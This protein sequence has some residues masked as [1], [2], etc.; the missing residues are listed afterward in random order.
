MDFVTKT[1]TFTTATGDVIEAITYHKIRKDGTPYKKPFETIAYKIEGDKKERVKR[2]SRCGN[3]ESFD[4]AFRIDKQKSDLKYPSC[5]FCERRYFDRYNRTAQ[6]RKRYIK[7]RELESKVLKAPDE[8]YDYLFQ[9]FHFNCAI[10]DNDDDGIVL[11]HVIPL[12]WG[13]VEK[14]KG[15]LLPMSVTLNKEKRNRNIFEFVKDLEP[16]Q[17]H[18]FY[19]VVLPFLASENN[20]NV[21]EYK[22]HVYHMEK[23]RY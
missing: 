9:A 18:R 22:D 5:I 10:L 7:R 17:Q 6:G 1:E 15:N 23:R 14:E 16:E 3:W 19:T 13:V 8:Y 11:D 12:S 4:H 20:M 21:Q 2:C